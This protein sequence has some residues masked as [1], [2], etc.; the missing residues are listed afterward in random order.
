MN[1][2]QI[3]DA[4]R[5]SAIVAGGQDALYGPSPLLSPIRELL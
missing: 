2:Y 4:E 3:G 1:N 5:D